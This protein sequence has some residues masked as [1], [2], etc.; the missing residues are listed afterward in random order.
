MRKT[1]K[2]V[3]CALVV[4]ACCSCSATYQYTA[5]KV[6]VNT[7]D[8]NPTQQAV[9]VKTDFSKHVTATSDYH[10]FVSS[11]KKEAEYRCL[12]NN[13]IDVIVDPIFQIEYNLF[14]FKKHCKATVIGF[15]GKYEEHP[16]GVE[17]TKDYSIE[18]IEKYKL[19][20]DDEFMRYYYAPKETEKGITTGDTYYINSGVNGQSPL[21]NSASKQVSQPL[22][23]AP[24][25]VPAPKKYFDYT[26]SKK[27]RNVGAG[28]TITGLTLAFGIA[29]PLWIY[30]AVEW[31]EEALVSGIVF[32]TVGGAM[33]LAGIPVWSVGSYRMKNGNNLDLSVNATQ[34][35]FGLGLTF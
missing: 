6:D 9:S 5:R 2:F 31:D 10:F 13:N 30:E 24:K 32:S 16:V 8:I 34:N 28:L 3:F 25:H 22:S 23:L 1:L 20:T 27:M 21:V 4:A 19:L 18:E 17:A 35:G 7:R 14:K 29:M 15:A 11:A 33:M 26:K 12:Q